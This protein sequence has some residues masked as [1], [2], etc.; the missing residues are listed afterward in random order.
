MRFI[1][2]NFENYLKKI[3]FN[4]G[5]FREQTIEK[6]SNS[7]ENVYF[8]NSDKLGENIRDAKIGPKVV[9]RCSRWIPYAI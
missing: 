2:E 6:F 7:T 9:A 1:K 3:F 8:K 4:F 5:I